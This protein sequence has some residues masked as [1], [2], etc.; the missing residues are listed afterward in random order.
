MNVVD[1]LV[2]G[3]PDDGPD[4]EREVGGD[5]VHEA[6]AREH[7]ELL[8]DHLRRRTRQNR[9]LSSSRRSINQLTT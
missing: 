8:H 2:G 6:E 9:S 7:A 4:P 5:E 3:L 1:P